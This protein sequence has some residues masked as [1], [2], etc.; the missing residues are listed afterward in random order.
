MKLYESAVRKPITTLLLFVAVILFG[1]YSYNRLA[2][3]LYPEIDPPFISVFTFY[4]GANAEDIETNISR[5]LEDN[6]NTVANLK[7]LTS[8][9][10]EN[11]SLLFLEFE[12]GANLDEATNSIR[13]ALSRITKSLPDGAE[14]PIIFKFNTTMIPI[15][16]F[17]VTAK[18]ST[19]ALAEIIED[20]VV[21]P[22]NRIDGVGAITI[23]GGEKREIM[24]D[25][26]PKRLEGY[27]LTVEQIGRAIAS[28]NLNMPAGTLSTGN[29]SVPLRV[30]GE[31][32]ASERL[33]NI[34]VGQFQGKNIRLDEVARVND[35]LAE[36]SLVVR[37]NGQRA[38]RFSIQ[39]QSGANAVKVVKEVMKM[40]PELERNLPQDVQ[41]ATLFNTSEF[42]E[43]SIDSLTETV[44]YAAL[45]VMLV[46][47]FFL[48]RWRAT[49]I[50]ILTIPVSLIA[51]F[52]YLF[53]SGNSINIIS[54][55][56]LS[57]AIGMVVDDA[58]VV[59]ENVTTHLERGGSPRAAGS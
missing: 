54:L 48:G 36:E 42:I 30:Q 52:I 40:L 55:S 5:I 46:I 10:Y 23:S 53:V 32:D 6:L 16:E 57:I 44:L 26:D 2:V 39:K 38:L 19:P 12:W 56:S 20:A 9:S 28:E 22:L 33:N 29:M 4:Q 8:S 47:L 35:S 7:K 24:V 11:Y 15:L 51:A 3:D 37:R 50:I 59:L 58:I 21:N 41:I 25:V 13:D 18:E 27:N 1:L 17:S 14:T 34:I 45:F 43:N 49:F 31:F